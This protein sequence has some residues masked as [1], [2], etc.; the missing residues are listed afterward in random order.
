MP[1]DTIVTVR[2]R[3]EWAEFLERNLATM[4]ERTRQSMAERPLSPE[5]R[6][7]LARRAML[8][9]RIDDAVL[10]ALVDG[11]PRT[12]AGPGSRP[13]RIPG[14]GHVRRVSAAAAA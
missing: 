1:E 5:R 9:A 10:D 13:P 12:D 3:R 8:L 6:N 7:D 2:L 4:L 11:V 14:R